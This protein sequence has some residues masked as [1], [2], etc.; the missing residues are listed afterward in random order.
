MTAFWRASSLSP[1]AR[2]FPGLSRLIDGRRYV[3]SPLAAGT[4]EWPR[5]ATSTAVDWASISTGFRS[6]SSSCRTSR[7]GWH[8]FCRSSCCTDVSSGSAS[9]SSAGVSSGGSTAGAAE[10]GDI[11]SSCGSPGMNSSSSVSVA[12][13]SGVKSTR[14]PWGRLSPSRWSSARSGSVSA[15]PSLSAT[16]VSEASADSV[17]SSCSSFSRSKI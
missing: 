1:S 3:F 17:F 4:A 8:T 11:L 7:T 13:S 9:L 16:T 5:G 12:L 15:A 6:A 2:G 14:W 10:T